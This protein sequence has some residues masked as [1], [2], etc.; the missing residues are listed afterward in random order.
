M[1]EDRKLKK[2]RVMMVGAVDWLRGSC[3]AE[4]LFLSHTICD[5]EK[6]PDFGISYPRSFPP[7]CPAS[8]CISC[9]QSPLQFSKISFRCGLKILIHIIASYLVPESWLRPK[10]SD[11]DWRVPAS[12]VQHQQRLV[13]INDSWEHFPS[14]QR[15]LLERKAA[16]VLMYWWEP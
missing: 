2:H 12:A 10:H 15:A 11:L 6:S 16:L 4:T 3:C 13:L 1:G 8:L 14:R 7:G 5:L 9:S